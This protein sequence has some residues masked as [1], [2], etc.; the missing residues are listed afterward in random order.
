MLLKKFS[1]RRWAL[2][3]AALSFLALALALFLA[4]EA[5]PR[6]PDTQQA[7]GPQEVARGRQLLRQLDPRG[8]AAGSRASVRL[9]EADLNA[10]LAQGGQRAQLAL[11]RDGAQLRASLVLP[12]G[13]WRPWL[14]IQLDLEAPSWVQGQAWP[15]LAGVR[16]GRLPLPPA[17]SLRLARWALAHRFGPEALAL[18]DLVEQV[19]FDTQSVWLLWRWEPAQAAA[20][21]AGIWPIAERQALHAQAQRWHVLTADRQPGS[22][23]DLAGLLQPLA[24][25]A[26]ERVQMGGANAEVELRALLLHLALR[27]VGRDVAPLLGEPGGPGRGLG[28]QLGGREDMAQHFLISAWLTWQGGQRLTEALGLAKE[29]SDAQRGGSGFSFNDLAADAA[30]ERFGRACAAAPVTLLAALA[31]GLRD[32]AFFPDTSDL[33]E[34]LPAAEFQRRFGGVTGAGYRQLRARIQS[35]VD[36]L[37]LYRGLREVAP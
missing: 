9:R 15:R 5:Q 17:L 16:V 36:G 4:L 31:T 7:L 2:G 34:F 33:P 6:V 23:I 19:R 30:G 20:A 11:A 21:L 12:L 29:L 8:R 13:P 24:A 27:A 35:R 26:L 22:A 32:G 25:T 10:L 28:L 3:L 18:A 14:N 1:L 37:P